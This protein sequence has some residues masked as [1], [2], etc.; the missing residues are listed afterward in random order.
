M[1]AELAILALPQVL[2]MAA[3]IYAVAARASGS[4]FPWSPYQKNIFRWV[5]TGS[6]NAIVNAVAGSGKSTVLKEAARIIGTSGLFCAFSKRIADDLKGPIKKLNPNFDVRTIHSLGYQA[7][8]AFYGGKFKTYYMKRTKYWGI[9]MDLV[10]AEM[11]RS[12]ETARIFHAPADGTKQ[13]RKAASAMNK[14][15]EML[16]KTLTDPSDEDEVHRIIGHYGITEVISGPWANWA[17]AQ[18]GE[19]MRVG[20]LMLKDSHLRKTGSRVLDYTDMLWIPHIESLPPPE[21]FSW[22]MVDEAQDLSIAQQYLMMKALK[23]GGRVLAV[24]DPKQSIFGF[25]GADARSFDNLATM[26]KAEHLPLSICYRCPTSHIELAQRLVPQIEAR[27]GAPAGEVENI[28]YDELPSRVEGGDLVL[29]RTNA[30]LLRLI[31]TLIKEKIPAKIIGT[32]FA[33]QL[34]KEISNIEDQHGFRFSE[35]PKFANRYRKELLDQVLEYNGGDTDDLALDRIN[36]MMDCI[37][38]VHD[39]NPHCSDTDCFEKVI[40]DLFVEKPGKHMVKLSSVHQAKGAEANRVFVM[41][42]DPFTGKPLMPHA[43]AKQDWEIE[44]EH[45]LI[46]VAW[47]RAKESLFFVRPDEGV[48]RDS[49]FGLHFGPGT[50]SEEHIDPKEEASELEKLE[51]LLAAL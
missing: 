21:Q 8:R 10:Q 44:Q 1:K 31:F 28:L 35:F 36:D 46:Y 25:A 24:G 45:N 3:V 38:A 39:Y 19:M 4:L 5:Q 18:M 43:L 14:L 34:V 41:D 37:L 48:G 47:T 7:I 51:R 42:H 50:E 2:M 40:K 32:D 13:Q 17:L 27:D 12:S 16:R 6:G 30:P 9:A 33:K 22:I 29:C 20:R 11:L 23:T 26:L 15:C 49:G